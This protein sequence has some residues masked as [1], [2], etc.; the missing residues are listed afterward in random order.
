[1]K[2]L[3]PILLLILLDFYVF[4]SVKIALS[5]V[6][7]QW[8][9]IGFLLFW[10]FTFLLLLH[11]VTFMI[12]PNL[13]RMG[14][15]FKFTRGILFVAYLGK[16]IMLPFLALDEIIR[17]MK[18]YD[19]SRNKFINTT[20]TLVGFL[21]LIILSYGII[22]NAYR[23][24]IKRIKVPVKNLSQDLIGLKII[25]ISDIHS[26]SFDIN[27][28]IE[29]GIKMI[30]DENPDLVFFTGDLVNNE[31]SEILPFIEKFKKINSKYGVFSITGN[32]DYGDYKEWDSIETKSQNFM[33][34]VDSHRKMGWNLLLNRHEILNIG[35]SSLGIIGVENFSGS[36]GFSRYGN[37]QKSILGLP[38]TNYNILL[39]H[40]PSHWDYEVKNYKE[41][42]LTLSG[43]THG[44]QFGIEIPGWIKW[45][46]AK[47]IYKQ[48]AGLYSENH[49]HLYV[50]RGF[51]FLGYPGRVGILPEITVLTLENA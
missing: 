44:F 26:G 24:T 35:D 14:A 38:S 20:A 49:Q 18:T 12:S 16:I 2:L 47:W 21:P 30:N 50:N 41:I 17:S 27:S 22:K 15:F 45:S 28:P 40:D 42:G 19:S 7:K 48:W 9:N 11:L 4:Q 46:P 1:M 51:G 23:Y 10:T 33:D 43:H 32:H 29:N 5:N 34:L 6:P 13:V 25:Q 39:S 8:S 3:I 31:A 36:K 37:L